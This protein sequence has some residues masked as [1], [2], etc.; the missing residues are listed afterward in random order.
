[1]FSQSHRQHVHKIYLLSIKYVTVIFSSCKLLSTE[2]LQRRIPLIL[3]RDIVSYLF[4]INYRSHI[5]FTKATSAERLTVKNVSFL[6][7]YKLV[8]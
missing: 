4:F 5:S 1:M 3:N 7:L 6:F 2:F 8:N